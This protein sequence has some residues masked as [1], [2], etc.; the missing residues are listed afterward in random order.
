MSLKQRVFAAAVASAATVGVVTAVAPAAGADV[1]P[2]CTTVTRTVHVP[3]YADPQWDIRVCVS[4]ETDG[5]Q[6][7]V[8]ARI[9]PSM[10]ARGTNKRGFAFT[11]PQNAAVL[12]ITLT[13]DGKTQATAT[14]GI[15]KDVK[16]YLS[17]KHHAYP[18]N[19]PGISASAVRRPGTWRASGR[20]DYDVSNDKRGAY[21]YPVQSPTLQ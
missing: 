11:H 10:R 18:L 1:K 9:E 5:A 6:E 13:L 16:Q 4:T 12:H 3:K 15:G 14:W 8:V 20:L 17:S 2:K 7:T 19:L 21:R